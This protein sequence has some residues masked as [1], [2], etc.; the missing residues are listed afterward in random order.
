MKNVVFFLLGLDSGGLENYLLRFLSEKHRCFDNVYVWCKGGKDG[1]LDDKFSAL[2]N[3]RLI[4][5]E[6][7]YFDYAQYNRAEE[8]FNI[9][10]IDIVC[11][12]TGNFAGRVML[13]ARNAGVKKRVA[14][15]RGSAD[16]FKKG[17]FR[18]AYNKWVRGLVLS[19]ATNIVFNSKAG[20]EYFFN[21]AWETDSRFSV[22]Y[23]GVNPEKFLAE[24]QNLRK[25]F[26]LPEKAYVIGHTGRF[27]PA[28]NHST[29][30]AVAETLV[31]KYPD[32]YFILCGNGVKNNLTS[33]LK[34]KG[35]DSRVLVFDNRTDIPRFLNTM[36]CYLFP[37]VTEGQPNALIEALIMGLPFVASD[38]AP[39][40]ETVGD[41][42]TLYPA[43]DVNALIDA[44]ENRYL[45][46]EGRDK[47][48]QEVMI[49]RFDYE[50][51]F[52][53]FHCVLNN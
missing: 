27:N 12:F 32:I 26:S 22:I 43:L 36:D 14:G 23:N 51:R 5:V 45:A 49:D 35:I 38:I 30:L 31:R 28:K 42:F 21:S 10:K 48:Q 53:E 29:I 24:Q 3:V 7:G 19:N 15:Y 25:E 41:D 9:N 13:S 34:A 47:S 37:S 1:Q 16:R 33:S 11:D 20:R 39:I 17:L 50:K 44:L 46:R 8:F 18:N 52:Y 2:A 6:L 4:K 40:R